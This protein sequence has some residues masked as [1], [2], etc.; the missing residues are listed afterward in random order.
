MSLLAAEPSGIH[1]PHSEY[2]IRRVRIGLHDP[3][4]TPLH[5]AGY[6]IEKEIAG[7]TESASLQ[8]VVE[9]PIKEEYFSQS[10]D[11]VS[12]WQQVKLTALMQKYW[13]DNAVSVTV[14]YKKD[15][16]KDIPRIMEHFERDLKSI[17]FLP[18]MDHGFAQAPLETITKE[19]YEEMTK[20]LKSV[21]FTDLKNDAIGVKYC[22]Q[23]VCEL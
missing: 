5:E 15:E 21:D 10:K 6:N 11:D 22:D 16:Q 18:L 3:I 13:A 7:G 14:T 12:V 2:Y 1:M 23:E 17:S 19:Q 20:N 4:L 8:R 9:F